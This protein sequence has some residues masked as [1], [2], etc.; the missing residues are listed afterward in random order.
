MLKIYRIKTDSRKS[1]TYFGDREWQY[2][3]E[4]LVMFRH[5]PIKD[6]FIIIGFRWAGNSPYGYRTEDG[7][8]KWGLKSICGRKH[9]FIFVGKQLYDA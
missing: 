6:K 5:C 2:I 4:Q 9:E 3:I 7:A 8:R 1:S